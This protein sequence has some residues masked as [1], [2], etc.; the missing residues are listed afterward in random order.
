MFPDLSGGAASPGELPTAHSIFSPISKNL[1]V[2][3]VPLHPMVLGG[4]SSS[5]C[6]ACI[7]LESCKNITIYSFFVIN[8]NNHNL[9]LL[10]ASPQ[11][12]SNL[13]VYLF[14]QK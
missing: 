8:K 6:H 9:Y 14:R 3:H 2:G 5:F 12:L 10:H 4:V 7:R 11:L 13:F 1:D